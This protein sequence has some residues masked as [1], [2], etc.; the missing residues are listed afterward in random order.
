MY[1]IYLR[2]FTYMYLYIYIFFFDYLYI[3]NINRIRKKYSKNIIEIIKRKQKPPKNKVSKYILLR[4]YM[5][6]IY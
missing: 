3:L 5:L 1:T 6:L 2:L 4:S